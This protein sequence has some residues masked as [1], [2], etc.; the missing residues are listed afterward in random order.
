MTFFL[1]LSLASAPPSG[2]RT[3]LLSDVIQGVNATDAGPPGTWKEPAQG[4]EL[5]LTDAAPLDTVFFEIE[6]PV[7]VEQLWGA[8]MTASPFMESFCRLRKYHDIQ[9]SHW[10]HIG[11]P[12]AVIQ[13]FPS[14]L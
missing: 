8:L 1:Q 11:M 7:T 5:M 4:K 9:A 2:S 6:L 3:A 12:H 14:L 10:R 13:V